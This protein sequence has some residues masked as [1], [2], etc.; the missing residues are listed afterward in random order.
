[1]NS[2]YR[3]ISLFLRIVWREMWG[4]NLDV[5]TAWEIAN[6]VWPKGEKP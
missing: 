4:L 5:A 6:I 1:M 2:T 3:R